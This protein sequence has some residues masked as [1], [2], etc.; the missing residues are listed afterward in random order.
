MMDIKDKEMEEIMEMVEEAGEEDTKVLT[1]KQEVE[2][3]TEEEVVDSNSRTINRTFSRLTSPMIKATKV[4]VSLIRHGGKMKEEIQFSCRRLV[5][6]VVLTDMT[7]WH[8]ARR[9]A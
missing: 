3:E 6:S 9:T 8:S 5:A 1:V 4:K 2:V 7:R